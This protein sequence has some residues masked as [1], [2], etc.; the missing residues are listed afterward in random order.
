MQDSTSALAVVGIDKT[1]IARQIKERF[2]NIFRFNFFM[3]THQFAQVNETPTPT[4]G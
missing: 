4:I 1:G 3:L 2:N